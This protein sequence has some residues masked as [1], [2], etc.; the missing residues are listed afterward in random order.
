M[1]LEDANYGN[2]DLWYEAHRNQSL[3]LAFSILFPVKWFYS[4]SLSWDIPLKEAVVSIY[5]RNEEF[6]TLV[7]RS[8]LCKLNELRHIKMVNRAGPSSQEEKF[9]TLESW[10]SCPLIVHPLLLKSR[11]F[12]NTCSRPILCSKDPRGGEACTL[13]YTINLQGEWPLR[14][15]LCVCV[16]T[17][18][19]VF[20]SWQALYKTSNL[21]LW[22]D[23]EVWTVVHRPL[24]RRQGCPEALRSQQSF[25]PRLLPWAGTQTKKWE[26]HS[27]THLFTQ[28]IFAATYWCKV[29]SKSL[30]KSRKCEGAAGGLARLESK[31]VFPK[32]NITNQNLSGLR[33][34][35]VRGSPV[36]VR[37][38]HFSGLPSMS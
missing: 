20:R 19:C 17:S 27:C 28:Q 2:S 14:Y 23:P 1:L 32:T 33:R 21:G 22:M 12:L 8:L 18:A 25:H 3:S 9:S 5:F 7:H 38:C 4:P 34:K 15:A 24:Q 37:I 13:G 10:L 35:E 6:M 30:S 11:C 26:R 31:T 16:C 36:L 29:L